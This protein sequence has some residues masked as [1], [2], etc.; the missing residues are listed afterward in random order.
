V[1]VAP[2]PA[3]CVRLVV[4]ESALPAVEAALAEQHGALVTDGPDA[5]GRVPVTLYLAAAPTRDALTACLAAAALA[6]GAE[7]PE[8]T[9][10]RLPDTDWVAES[11]KALPALWVG[12]FY[13]YGAHVAEAPPE[14]SIPLLIEANVAFGTGRH[15]STRGCLLAL[16]DLA[17]ARRVARPLDMG[18]GSGVLALAIAKLWGV[19]VLAVDSDADAVRVTAEN[20]ALN[21]VAAL[22]RAVRGEGYACH[23]VAARGPFDLIVANILAEPLCVLAPDLLRHLA[24]DGAAVLSGLLA[25]QA[26]AVIAAHR[27]LEVRRRYPLGEW[28]TLVLAR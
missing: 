12:P 5:A 27:G 16:A 11:Q 8:F 28:E 21:G 3:W 9:I 15:E 23:E 7:V 14:D 24:A 26:D 10:E 2:A 13:L 17:P 18:C 1:D 6:A 22:V 20:A 19:P 25:S 4:P